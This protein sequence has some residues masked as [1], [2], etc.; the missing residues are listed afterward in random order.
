ML[1]YIFEHSGGWVGD[2]LFVCEQGGCFMF[3]CKRPGRSKVSM[4]VRHPLTLQW[5]GLK[6]RRKTGTLLPAAS[7]RRLAVCHAICPCTAVQAR[8]V[9]SPSRWPQALSVMLPPEGRWLGRRQQ[10]PALTPLC[11][12]KSVSSCFAAYTPHTTSFLSVRSFVLIYYGIN[13]RNSR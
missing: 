3:L 11:I 1:Y 6:S 8:P 13:H 10:E 12:Q 7:P 2:N 4:L 5:T 9:L